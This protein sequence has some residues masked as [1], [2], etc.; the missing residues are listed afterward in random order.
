MMFLIT[1]IAALSLIAGCAPLH[2]LRLRPEVQI[3]ERSAVIFFVDGVS[4][5]VFDDLLRRR[6]L[7]N[8]ERIFI[9]GGVRVEHA[10][11]CLPSVTYANTAAI[12]T[13][14]LPSHT[15]IVGNRWFDRE[16]LDFR[17]YRRLDQHQQVNSDL[18]VP[19]LYEILSDRFTVNVQCHTRRGVTLTTDDWLSNA[20]DWGLGLYRNVDRRVGRRIRHIAA[21]A[22]AR[23]EWPTVSMFYFPATDEIGHHDGARSGDYRDA[24]ESVDERIGEIQRALRVSG[25]HGHM[26]YVF[27][28]D[29]GHVPAR[30]RHVFNIVRWLRRRCGLSVYD[31]PIAP[32]T[33][34]TPPTILG[35]FDVFAIIS[36]DRSATLHVRGINGWDQPPDDALIERILRG[37]GTATDETPQALV[38]QPGVAFVC[39][40]A[41]DG[42]VRILSRAGE[43]R[44]DS[45][46]DGAAALR[47]LNGA[48]PLAYSSVPK[49]AEFVAAGFHTPREWLEAT[50]GTTYPD[51]VPQIVS[52]FESR[53]A[54]DIVVFADGDWAFRGEF[55]GN[56]GSC[57]AEDM[58]VPLMFAGAGLPQGAT[59]PLARLVDVTPTIIDLLGEGMRLDSLELD[60]VSRAAELRDAQTLPTS[61]R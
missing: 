28:S 10:I 26:L 34:L 44:V 4:N 58:R 27:V 23:G 17:D 36:A 32:E 38:D 53:R 16:T 45:A 50:A 40:R 59:I 8:I 18:L 61:A 30:E 11:D 2:D 3:P 56:H 19:T 43:T 41:K 57:R 13:G 37:E 29:H 20:I 21:A 60:G 12:L 24:L 9:R 1:C 15:G 22:N 54:G 51:F 48:D 5:A 6:K 42:A 31:E 49:L 35:L 33:G 25:L 39:T 47:S 7:P 55:Q 46:A 14:C 52:L